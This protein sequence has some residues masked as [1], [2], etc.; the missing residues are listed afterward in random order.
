MNSWHPVLTWQQ[1]GSFWKTKIKFTKSYREHKT[2]N[3][4]QCWQQLLDGQRNWVSLMEIKVKDQF[5]TAGSKEHEISSISK[6]FKR[7][8]FGLN[9]PMTPLKMV[10][11]QRPTFHLLW[12]QR[13]G[14][15]EKGRN[16]IGEPSNRLWKW[17]M[18]V[19]PMKVFQDRLNRYVSRIILRGSN[20]FLPS[21]PSLPRNSVSNVLPFRICASSPKALLA[22]PSAVIPPL[23]MGLPSSS[24]TNPFL[25]NLCTK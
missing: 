9:L 13:R 21:L 6:F 11:A 20:D 25:S 16:S 19:S 22:P 17:G 4:S 5:R 7:W 15:T 23:R 1:R 3:G 12:R 10:L 18:K 2:Q 24:C 14:E 8:T